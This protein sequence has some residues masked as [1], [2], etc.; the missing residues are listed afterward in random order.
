[1]KVVELKQWLS[2]VDDEVVVLVNHDSEWFNIE[3][4]NV[5]VGE[6]AI[7]LVTTDVVMS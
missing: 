4:D 7:L 2:D 5:V 3:A 6:P 1:M